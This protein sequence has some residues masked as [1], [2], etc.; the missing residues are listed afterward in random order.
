[1]KK[2]K[3]YVLQVIGK[4]PMGGIGNVLLNYQ[5]YMNRQ[6]I[7]M[8]YLIFSDEAD[9]LFDRKVRELGSRI[10]VL[11]ALREYRVLYLLYRF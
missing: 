6:E 1:M 3:I 8:D 5:T 7:Q 11:P 2:R 10:D 9:G 4:R